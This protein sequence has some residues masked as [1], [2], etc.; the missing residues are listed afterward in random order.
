MTYD[1]HGSWDPET[2]HNAPLYPGPVD[3]GFTVVSRNYRPNATLSHTAHT[4]DILRIQPHLSSLH[5][6]GG[7]RQGQKG[8]REGKS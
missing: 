3:D 2:G 7:P 4:I 6:H 5:L 1:M 8:P